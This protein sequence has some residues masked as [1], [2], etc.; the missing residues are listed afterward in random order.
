MQYCYSTL[1]GSCQSR[2]WCSIWRLPSVQRPYTAV[3]GSSQGTSPNF[4][5]SKYPNWWWQD[6][7]TPRR[8]A[9]SYP[10]PQPWNFRDWFWR[11]PRPP[12]RWWWPTTC[13]SPLHGFVPNLN[14]ATHEIDHLRN[15]AQAPPDT[16]VLTM[17]VVHGTPLSECGSNIA[18]NAFPT[19]FPTG[20]GGFDELRQHK[21]TEKDW[22]NY[23]LQL[24][25]GQFEKHPCFQY[26]AL[27]TILWHESKKASTWYQSIQRGENCLTTAQV[28]FWI[29]S[30]NIYW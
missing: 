6:T 12:W 18:V 4:P 23:L 16:P 5:A 15:A 14:I 2:W 7:T 9:G 26:W 29:Q 21:V 30:W 25:G 1:E 11:G 3:V 8:W 10:T 13:Q 28:I 27:N 20:R 19:L 22:A 24:C 17:P